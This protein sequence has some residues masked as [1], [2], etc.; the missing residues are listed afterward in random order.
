M[1]ARAAKVQHRAVHEVPRSAPPLPAADPICLVVHGNYIHLCSRLIYA[2][3]SSPSVSV[4]PLTTFPGL[5]YAPQ[6]DNRPENRR[7]LYVMLWEEG[8]PFFSSRNRVRGLAFV[9]ISLRSPNEVPPAA[10]SYLWYSW[11]WCLLCVS[12][13]ASLFIILSNTIQRPP[14][15]VL[16]ICFALFISLGGSLS[17]VAT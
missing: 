17:C 3:R 12:L 15:W 5:S 14:K 16:L 4:L 13:M 1:A 6:N 11:G 10:R 8:R 9:L 7:R 2:A